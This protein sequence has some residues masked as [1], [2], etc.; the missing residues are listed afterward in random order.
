[1]TKLNK[2]LSELQ[3]QFGESIMLLS[4]DKAIPHP[5]ISTG[6]PALDDA[7]GI[8][9][10]PVGKITEIF[11]E[12]ASGKSTL[13][14]STVAQ[15]QKSG[16]NCAFLDAEHVLDLNRVKDLD[17]K[18]D[19]LVF[20]QP[21]YGE[22]ALEMV[23][24]IAR[25]GSVKVIVVDSVAALIPKSELEGDMGDSPMASQARLLSQAMRKLVGIINK[26]DV[27][28][29]FVNQLRSNITTYGY[30]GKVTT[31]GNALKYYASVRIEMKKKGENTNSEGKLIS[32]DHTIKIRKN[33]FA[34][35]FKSVTTQ[36]DKHGFNFGAELVDLGLRK[37]ILH[38]AGAY[39]K[40]GE[41]TLG[42]GKQE[43]ADR[44][45]GDEELAQKIM[46]LA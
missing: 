8:G 38:R 42:Q 1:M 32:T 10:F 35:P 18:L 39:Y 11:G 5:S 46:S 43:T 37:K 30:G 4:E 2:A 26:M 14:L 31:G 3:K 40:L 28:L 23:D 6:S 9:G 16:H 7:L 45:K 15:A 36:I 19:K 24:G 41:E 12:E 17:V 34:P 29:I 13:A 44:I 20:A 33:K 27:V 21:D 22:Q 25:S